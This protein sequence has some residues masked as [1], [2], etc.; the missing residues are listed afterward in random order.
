MVTPFNEGQARLSPDGRYVAFASNESG[1]AEVYVQALPPGK[2]RWMV[3]TNGGAQPMWRGD[4]RELYY[5]SSDYA[6]VAVPITLGAEVSFGDAQRLFSVTLNES[7]FFAVRNH[8][9]VSPDGQRFLVNSVTGGNTLRVI[10]NWDESLRA[11]PTTRQQAYSVRLPLDRPH[12]MLRSWPFQ[13]QNAAPP[14]RN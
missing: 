12:A 7:P 1:R 4:G 2:G 11:S 13:R 5:L 3:S 8:Y 10:L 6:I 9:S 14:T